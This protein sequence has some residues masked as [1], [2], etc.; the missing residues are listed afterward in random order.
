MIKPGNSVSKA[1]V[2]IFRER[3]IILT[4][5]TESIKLNM[6]IGTMRSRPTLEERMSKILLIRTFGP[7]VMASWVSQI[8]INPAT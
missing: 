7:Y 4:V 6:M 1:A 5:S 2:K 3:V 8:R